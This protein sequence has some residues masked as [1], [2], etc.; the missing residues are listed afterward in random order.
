[1]PREQRHTI[2]RVK[3]DIDVGSVDMAEKIKDEIDDFIK[4]EVMPIVESCFAKVEHDLGDQILR[5]DKLE[6]NVDTS[7]W[8]IHSYRLKQE[9][10]SEVEKQMK[11]LL[12]RA[13]EKQPLL[14]EDI[15]DRPDAIRDE[16]L[17]VYGKGER[18]LRSFFHFL[19]QGILP[20]WNNSREESRQMFSEKVLLDAIGQH[21]DLVKREL[22]KKTRADQFFTRL[23][24]QFPTSI[25]T[26]IMAIRLSGSRNEQRETA[27]IHEM[28]N[29]SKDVSQKVLTL[30]WQ[31]SN[32][33][34]I[35]ALFDR[36]AASHL[37][38][39]IHTHFYRGKLD[40]NTLDSALSTTRTALNFVYVLSN[41][42][43]VLDRMKTI[44]IQSLNERASEAVLEKLKTTETYKKLALKLNENSKPKSSELTSGRSQ[45]ESESIEEFSEFRDQEST[46]HSDNRIDR[47]EDVQLKSD[48]ELREKNTDKSADSR[49]Q[50]ED[51]A[52][53]EIDEA[54]INQQEQLS[55][56]LAQS[57][58]KRADQDQIE[59]Q[60]IEQYK[61]KAANTKES[62]N[63]LNP[64][65]GD[66]NNS[67]T[68][69]KKESE[70][71]VPIETTAKS[72][73]N[74]VNFD[75]KESGVLAD[76]QKKEGETSRSNETSN[77]QKVLDEL[78]KDADSKLKKMD[79]VLPDYMFVNNA[80]LVLL[81]P[82]LPALFKQL[83]L[84]SESGK[85]TDP[86]LAACILHYAAT[87]REGDFE[88]EMAFEKY[89]C[90]I[91]PSVSLNK[92]IALS[93]IQKEEVEKVLNSVLTYWEVM[94]NKPIALLQN[95][96]LSRSGKLITEKTN[97]RLL[98]ERKT[99]DLLLDKLPW[100]Y[101]MI[102]FSWKKELIFVEW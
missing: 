39:Y 2:E 97:H 75:T 64:N 45:K 13:K 70:N 14:K 84:L 8:S 96:F 24:Q 5:L 38:Q 77:L 56:D 41:R 68:D 40:S 88:F 80:G 57:E 48:T 28:E 19:D 73:K 20:W 47:S 63:V 4:N 16:E 74:D 23:I 21:T 54:T 67:I 43:K 62:E 71:R 30:L 83:E 53:P 102:K 58:R 79:E 29:L 33:N 98:I 101:S 82:F 25:L 12:E 51:S 10:R 78:A 87:G 85:L 50:E 3:V 22:E 90:G 59:N 36:A 60:Q 44:L 81:N 99:F 94:K 11:P 61:V 34:T 55:E 92:E 32:D 35:A 86:E 1:M 7:S 66:S 15:I 91:S 6:L 42:M 76:S 100:S 65:Q 52:N 72:E 95:E 93:D 18:V 69:L 31:L 89:L 9:I 37:F 17:Q 27:A 49:T 46:K 26:T